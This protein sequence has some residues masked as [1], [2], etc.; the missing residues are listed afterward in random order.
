MDGLPCSPIPRFCCLKIWFFFFKARTS[1]NVLQQEQNKQASDIHFY[2]SHFNASEQ[3][4][5]YSIFLLVE[6]L[7][8][9]G[10]NFFFKTRLTVLW[11][12]ASTMVFKFPENFR[13]IVC[14]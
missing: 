9:K 2:L 7:C 12:K 6:Y 3:P 5:H 13:C 11:A 14:T 4:S 10:D 1:S 8:K